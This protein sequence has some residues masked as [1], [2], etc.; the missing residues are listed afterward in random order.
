MLW[1]V[2]VSLRVGVPF[3]NLTSDTVWISVSVSKQT[4]SLIYSDLCLCL[5]VIVHEAITYIDIHSKTPL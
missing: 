5:C 4:Q 1:S 3:M 2:L